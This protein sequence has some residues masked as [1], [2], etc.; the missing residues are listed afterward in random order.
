[1]G[2]SVIGTR[3]YI[4]SYL[5]PSANGPGGVLY[6]MPLKGGKLTPRVSG[7]VAA[8]VGLGEHDGWLYIGELNGQVFRWQ[9]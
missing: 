5:G 4:T 9:P 7:F 6:S 1:M 3:L 8:I 2:L